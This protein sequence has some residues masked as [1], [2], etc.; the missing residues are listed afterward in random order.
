LS[1]EEELE[2]LSDEDG[3]EE[4]LSVAVDASLAADDSE[5]EEEALSLA[6]DSLVEERLSFL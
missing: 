6:F 1:F 5:V 2:E 3:L 4:V